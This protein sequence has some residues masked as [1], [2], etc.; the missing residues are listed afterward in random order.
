MISLTYDRAVQL[1]NDAVKE[2]GHDYVYPSRGEC[3]YIKDGKP[4][5]IV[6]HVLVAAGLPVIAFGGCS[7]EMRH[8]S[9]GIRH[10]SKVLELDMDH[11]TVELLREVQWSQDNGTPWGQAVA[12]ELA[13]REDVWGRSE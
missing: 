2:K 12:Q 6:G 1:L 4:S 8:N 13:E 3:V 7:G 5:C 9:A 11:D 10:L